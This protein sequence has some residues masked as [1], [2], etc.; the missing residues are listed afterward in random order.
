MPF[1]DL[2]HIMQRSND[3]TVSVT[4]NYHTSSF[5]REAVRDGAMGLDCEWVQVK[6]SRRPVALLQMATSSGLCV[7]VRLSHLK[8][9]TLPNLQVR[10]APLTQI[11]W[12][13]KYNFQE[14]FVTGFPV[15]M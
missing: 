12:S 9:I 5:C 7:L 14:L 10:S 13:D 6:G 2:Y 11:Y 1:L 8:G 4:H 3:Q 15:Y